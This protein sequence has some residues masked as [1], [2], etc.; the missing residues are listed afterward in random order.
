M[1]GVIAKTNHCGNHYSHSNF[2][3]LQETRRLITGFKFNY[4]DEGCKIA[5]QGQVLMLNGLFLQWV[6]I[7]ALQYRKLLVIQYFSF[8]SIGP[9]NLTYQIST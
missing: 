8:R 7:T 6:N 3:Q 4:D 5:N 1:E 2:K 9:Q